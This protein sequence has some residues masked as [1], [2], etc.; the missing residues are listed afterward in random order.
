MNEETP[1]TNTDL[2]KGSARERRRQ[3]QERT[4]ERQRVSPSPVNSSQ[5]VPAGT[6]SWSIPDISPY[7]MWGRVA[8]YIAAAV[9]LL[10]GVVAFLGR[11]AQDEPEL[12][13]NG[14]WIGTEW[15]YENHTDEEIKQLADQFRDHKIGSVY[16]WVSW[17]QEDMTW[18]GAQNFE[19]VKQF[20]RQFRNSYPDV[21][22]YG[23]V[24]LPVEIGEAG[25]RMDDAE[26]QQMVAD[27]SAVVVND[28][29][30]DGVFLNIEPVWNNDQNFLTL[31]RKVRVS[32]GDGALVAAAIPPD[33]SP[34]DAGIPVPPL[35]VPGTVWDKE[36]KQ[37][38]ALLTDQMLIMAY[39]SGLSSSTDYTIWMAYQVQTF[40]S[41]VAELQA[42]TR[43]MIG[44]PTYPAEL[45]G[46][47][48]LVE[49]VPSALEGLK[50]GLTQLGET[51]QYVQGVA[52]YAS[53]ETDAQEWAQFKTGWVMP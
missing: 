38:V 45:P 53:W 47:D 10:A 35:I 5:L 24:S 33:W 30:F 31:L 8:L 40:A 3:R 52:I 27:F 50:A 4:Q 25:Y 18:R 11:L 39:N 34:I 16:A 2:R 9:V 36:Y 32:V 21:R 6:R 28:F 26:V 19:N 13:P 48:P 51:A 1:Q 22:L 23:W 49:N 12:P 41:A 7:A 46:H 17:L 37:S 42:D 20:V 14:I 43:I 29:G 44:I 15:T